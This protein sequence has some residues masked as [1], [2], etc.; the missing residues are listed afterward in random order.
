[1]TTEK[2]ILCTGPIDEYATRVLEPFGEIVVAKDPAGPIIPLLEDTVAMVVRGEAEITKEVIDAGANLKVIARSGVGY[3][4]VDVG[5]A[6]ARGIPIVFTPGAMVASMAEGAI[7]MMLAMA[8]KL[9]YW[10]QQM[11]AGNWQSRFVTDHIDLEGKSLGVVGVGRIGRRTVQLAQAFGMSVSAFDPYI[12]AADAEEMSITLLSLED[13]LGQSDFICIHAALTDETKGLINGQNLKHLKPG[14]YLVNLAR[15]GLIEN[16]DVLHAALQDGRLRAVGLDVFEP[17]PPDVSHPIFQHPNCLTA[18]HVLGISK[19]AMDRVF[20][21]MADDMA[22][23][24]RGDA[25]RHVV[26]P[27]V[28]S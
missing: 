8:K 17:E 1:M 14:A 25:P 6:T 5:A 7:A 13:L 28:L 3:N 26:N 11:K 2:K 24:L 10:D 12:S 20:K 23:I 4:N 18:P 27:E 9:V 22:A 15:G 16:L 19:G 21:S